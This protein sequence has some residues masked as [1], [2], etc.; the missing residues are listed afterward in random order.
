[1]RLAPGYLTTTRLLTINLPVTKLEFAAKSLRTS[2]MPSAALLPPNPDAF[3]PNPEE[4]R[5][6]GK[7][8]GKSP[9]KN[10]GKRVVLKQP[11]GGRQPLGPER[12][13]A[14]SS[15]DILRI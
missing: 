10:G 1:V 5:K 7:N 14:P 11:K 2:G 15:T 4:E 12:M 8:G 9:A 6:E 13:G 3:P